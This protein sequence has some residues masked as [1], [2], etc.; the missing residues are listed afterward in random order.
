MVAATILTASL[1]LNG[2]SEAFGVHELQRLVQVSGEPGVSAQPVA[3][4]PSDADANANSVRR[5]TG[6]SLLAGLSSLPVADITA[7]VQGSPGQVDSLLAAPPAAAEVA[8]LWG[9]LGPSERSSLLAA[10]PRLVG[11]LDGIPFRERGRANAR[12]LS[13]SLAEVERNLATT[14]DDAERQLFTRERAVLAQVKAALRAPDGSPR[15]SLIL[16]DPADG[17]RAAIALG[18]PDAADYVSYLVPGMNYGVEP[19]IVNWT[20]TAEAVYREQVGVLRELAEAGRGPS[21]ESVATV[22]WIGY[23]APDLFSVGGLDRAEIGADFLEESSLGIRAERGDHQPFISVLAHSYGSTVALTALTRGSFS[24]DALVLVG[25]PGSQIQTVN[26]LSVAHGNVYVGKADWDPAVSSGF[27]GS[28]PGAASYGAHRLGV[29]GARDR[30]TGDWLNGSLGHNAY[31]D[32]GSESLHNM[33]LIGT[34]NAALVTDG[35]E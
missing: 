16:L 31:F 15:R 27:F 4:V 20:S 3:S 1:T 24:V 18:N 29:V 23:E 8:G 26:R 33:A 14:T 21:G 25:S 34:G 19:Q 28:D 11:N 22:A 7:F 35:S 32:V 5:M 9:G 10:A 12:Y 2:V 17:G 6:T 30:I 13:Q